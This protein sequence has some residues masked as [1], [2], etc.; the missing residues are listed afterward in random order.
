ME[1]PAILSSMSSSLGNGNQNLMVI[2]FMALLSTKI[3]QEPSFFG[4]S[5]VGIT[6]GLRL[7]CINF[8]VANLQQFP[9]GHYVLSGSSYNA[10][11]L[12]MLRQVENQFDVA[13]YEEVADKRAIHMA[14]SYGQISGN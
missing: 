6:H 5:N 8:F 4:M 3:C 11:E 13:S 7:G 2:L 9:V 1:A 10:V 14:N 12:A